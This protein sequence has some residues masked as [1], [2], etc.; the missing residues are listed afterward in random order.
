MSHLVAPTI[1]LCP[2]C[3]QPIEDQPACDSIRTGEIWKP[4]YIYM[5][6][7][8]EEEALTKEEATT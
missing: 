1:Y 4:S 2:Q 6:P 5:H 7:A 3:G 8:C